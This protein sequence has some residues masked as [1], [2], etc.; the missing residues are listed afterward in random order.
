MSLF[1][2]AIKTNPKAQERN[3]AWI[4]ALRSGEYSQAQGYL[5]TETGFCCLG[6]ACH[7]CDPTKWSP[8]RGGGGEIEPHYRYGYDRSG[9]P[10]QVGEDYCLR[11]ADGTFG[12]RR[13]TDQQESLASLNDGGAS[14]GEIADVIERELAAALQPEVAR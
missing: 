14:F 5:R 1:T 11:D 3:R 9:L 2:P 8:L 6:V 10:F 12:W 7:L 4:A 13:G